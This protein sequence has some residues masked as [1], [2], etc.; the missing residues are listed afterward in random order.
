MSDG[1]RTTA[2]E[3]LA[4]IDDGVYS[5]DG[6]WRF[7]YINAHA[8]CFMGIESRDA[9]GRSLLTTFPQIQGSP[10]HAAF[11]QVMSKRDPVHFEA[12]GVI[13]PLWHS[14]G[15]YPARDGGIFV[16]FR[17]ISTRKAVEVALRT[18]TTVPSLRI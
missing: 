18:Q 16:H 7:T 5:I 14:F 11:R 3:I 8:S 15:V 12:V 6:Q 10:I 1:Y 4:G 13:V 2:E 17:D 9:I